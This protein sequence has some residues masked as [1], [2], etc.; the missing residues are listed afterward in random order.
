MVAPA[1][2]YFKKYPYVT[3]SVEG[4]PRKKER[5]KRKEGSYV[6]FKAWPMS[7]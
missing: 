4:S 3:F 6:A 1:P 5:N 7:R 2:K